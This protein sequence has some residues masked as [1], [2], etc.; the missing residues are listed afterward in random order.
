M[1]IHQTLHDPGHGPQDRSS[2]RSLGP[3]LGQL[4][5]WA[6][7]TASTPGLLHR[8]TPQSH[9]R[10]WVALETPTDWDAWLVAWPGGSDTGWHDHQG[11]AGVFFVVQGRLTEFSL[12]GGP[13]LS[14]DASVGGWSD[15]RT[16]RVDAGRGRAF[17]SNHVH[18]VVNEY[19][20]TAYSV[21]VYSPKLRGMTRYAWQDDA[22][23][24]AGTERAGSW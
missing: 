22:L 6:A 20:G 23:L 19:E 11:A 12:A 1:T 13:S 24:F 3:D 5:Q 16:R 15:V 21:H 7:E 2:L 10:S 14:S 8:L 4:L 18:H 9:E 17:G